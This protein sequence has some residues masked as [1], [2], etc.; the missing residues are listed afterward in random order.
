METTRSVSSPSSSAELRS[1]SPLLPSAPSLF[2]LSP[3]TSP[4]E[5]DGRRL[6][7]RLLP[8]LPRSPVAPL[9][10]PT[11][12]LH[13]PPA[14]ALLA[15]LHRNGPLAMAS[16]APRGPAS[17]R[18][19][20]VAE[21]QGDESDPS[22]ESETFG[23][24]LEACA[25][26]KRRIRD[27]DTP[28]T[29]A[30]ARETEEKDELVEQ[31]RELQ[32]QVLFLEQVPSSRLDGAAS[33]TGRRMDRKRFEQ[34]MNNRLL[35]EAVR[36]Q[37]FQLFSAQS[38]LSEL[39]VRQQQTGRLQSQWSD[40]PQRRATLEAMKA[41]KLRDAKQLIARRTQFL[42]DSVEKRRETA[43]FSADT[44]ALCAIHFDV[45][46]LDGK[47]DTESA[48]RAFDA[49]CKYAHSLSTLTLT[50]TIDDA[51]VLHGRLQLDTAPEMP[52]ESSFVVFSE[53]QL[54]Q[55]PA[56]D[57]AKVMPVSAEDQPEEE[58][59]VEPLGVL[60]FDSVDEDELHPYRP[61]EFLREDV[62]AVVTISR[63]SR[64]IRKA[65]EPGKTGKEER[66]PC[67]VLTRWVL[68]TL[69]PNENGVAPPRAMELLGQTCTR[70]GDRMVEAVREACCSS[71][72]GS[73]ASHPAAVPIACSSEVAAAVAGS[74]TRP[75]S[76]A[77]DVLEAPS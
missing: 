38:A 15:F 46:P 26:S 64:R 9:L 7:P 19:V 54:P 23:S 75:D 47:A 2:T 58:A 42:Q 31:I 66:V 28:K 16:E 55:S 63:R 34:E 61:R 22:A 1:M 17:P 36:N 57:E 60:V 77:T 70:M 41:Q 11:P 25:K 53:M 20:A 69:H 44:G 8:L 50:D 27:F 59:E 14:Q 24:V 3:L 21:T 51:G 5:P 39:M 4:N 45:I 72:A 6:L 10:S 30:D 48:V 12:R 68:L 29:E 65:Q 32:A 52:T 33:G 73:P 62:N 76:D 35:R 74:P 43:Q 56:S 37:H 71:V 49:I 67:L 40:L 13:E 18:S